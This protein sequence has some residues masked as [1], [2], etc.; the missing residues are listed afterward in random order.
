VVLVDGIRTLVNIIIIDPIQANLVLQVVLSCGFV[1]D[2]TLKMT[3]ITIDT[4][5]IGFPSTCSGCWVFASTCQQFSSLMCQHGME[6]ERF[7]RPSS[8]SFMFIL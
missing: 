3:F 8:F 5:H 6:C 4:Q 2:P 7:W 1:V